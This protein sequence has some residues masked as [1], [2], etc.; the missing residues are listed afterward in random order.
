MK[1]V[2][3]ADV[4]DTRI[5][6]IARAARFGGRTRCPACGYSRKL[7]KLAGERWR[8][9][10]CRKRFGLFT[11]TWL[12]HVRFSLEEI[13]ELLFWFELGLTDR[14]IARRLDVAYHRVHR[15]FLRLREAIHAFEERS[16]QLLDGKVEV[17]E[18]YFG[19]TFKN[20]R[21]ATRQRLK[22]SGKVKRGR[23]AKHLQQTVFGI[24]ERSDGIVYISPVPDASKDSLQEIIHEKV[25]IETTIYSDT[26][27]SY[28]GLEDDFA[29]HETINHR[30]QQY[31][32]GP[33]TINGIEGFWAYAK[34]RLLRP[35][36]VSSQHFLLY[37]K[38]ME[39]RFNHRDLSPEEFSK[40]LLSVLLSE[41][42]VHET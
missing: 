18:T 24:Y 27:R 4:S 16:I 32:R 20:R 35:H 12:A 34:E 17:D 33:V 28:R 13:Y 9:K 29:G 21:R 26:W 15:F 6:S 36:G 2:F 31:V 14:G 3:T 30:E 38:E 11:G 19:A 40:H 39:Y 22:K 42:L 10:R 5:R 37:L 41:K 8:C 7:W 25:H 1:R 23:G